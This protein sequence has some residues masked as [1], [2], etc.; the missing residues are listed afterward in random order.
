[1]RRF[2]PLIPPNLFISVAILSLQIEFLYLATLL[3]YY[4]TTPCYTLL[5]LAILYL[6]AAAD[7]CALVDERILQRKSGIFAAAFVDLVKLLLDF[8]HFIHADD[9]SLKE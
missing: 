5:H 2:F 9:A 7:G 4:T 6:A 8:L 3:H 1:M